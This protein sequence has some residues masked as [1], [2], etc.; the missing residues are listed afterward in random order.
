MKEQLTLAGWLLGLGRLVGQSSS[1]TLDGRVGRVGV[2]GLKLVP[3]GVEGGSEEGGVD[4]SSLCKSF[5][6]W[7]SSFKYSIASPKI[8][9]LSI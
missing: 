3:V 8:D 1:L 7:S 4:S 2:R 9:A 6:F 5:I